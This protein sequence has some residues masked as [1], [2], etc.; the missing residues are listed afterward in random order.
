MGL[1]KYYVREGKNPKSGAA[2][3]FG[4]NL[5]VS[6]VDINQLCE[7][8]SHTTTVTKADVLAILTETEHQFINLMRSNKSVR[9]GLLG[10]F[11]TTVQSTAARLPE[12][13]TRANLKRIAVR[14]TPTATMKMQLKNGNPE[15]SFVK[16]T[17]NE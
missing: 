16:Q 9:F 3:Y 4:Q 12:E 8:V 13:F 7:E 14:F 2:Q 6:V 1:I 5:P 11:R 10:S 15:L 17:P